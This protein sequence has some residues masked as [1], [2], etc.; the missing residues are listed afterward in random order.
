VKGDAAS[1][2]KELRGT[3][4]SHYFPRP[5]R[6]ESTSRPKVKSA[7][8]S[9]VEHYLDTVG[10]TGSN[11]VSR[12]IPKREGGKSACSRLVGAVSRRT[13]LEA[14]GVLAYY[15]YGVWSGAFANDLFLLEQ[16]NRLVPRLWLLATNLALSY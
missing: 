12:T 2:K 5:A 3:P 13:S 15:Q 6:K 10:V 9:V 1:G 7:V 14:L 11:P 8:S 4:F 16:K